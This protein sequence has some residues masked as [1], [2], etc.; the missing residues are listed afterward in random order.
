MS[1]NSTAGCLASLPS[2]A[3][4]PKLNQLNVLARVFFDRSNALLPVVFC[5][6]PLATSAAPRLT[7]FFFAIV[8][9]ALIGA[10]LR[11]G[12]QWRELLP[13]GPALAA[14]L[15]LAAYVF[16]NATWSAIGRPLGF[17]RWMH[18]TKPCL[19]RCSS[20]FAER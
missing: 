12:I 16:L 20:F 10:A 1:R 17:L 8:S 11:R 3:R 14:C 13:R 15:L 5:I 18:E 19:V 4:A 6:S 2:S 9:I 7:P